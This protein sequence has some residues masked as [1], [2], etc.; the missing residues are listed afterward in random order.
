VEGARTYH[1][2][3]AA[4]AYVY[5]ARS[6]VALGRRTEV[7]SYLDLSAN[8]ESPYAAA[9]GAVVEGLAAEDPAERVRL[10]RSGVEGLERLSVQAERGRALVDLAQA[11]V[12]AGMPPAAT[13]A[14]AREVLTSCGALGWLPELDRVGC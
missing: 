9:M 14:E 2:E 5:M 4:E 11:E 8:A 3:A 12:D 6:L 13:I 10:I 1:V 7:R